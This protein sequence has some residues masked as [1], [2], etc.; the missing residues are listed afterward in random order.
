MTGDAWFTQRGWVPFAFQR[1]VWGAMAA[2]RSGLLHASTGSGKTYAVWFGA[3]ARSAGAILLVAQVHG[4]DND[5]QGPGGVHVTVRD[6]GPGIPPL[7]LEQIFEAFVQSSTTRDGS[8]G[9]GL[10]L[11]ISRKIIAAHGGSIRAEN[12]PDGGSRFHIYL[13]PVRNPN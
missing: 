4:G 7:E 3:L 8:G 1:E 6:H 12:R 13:P 2:G 11:A 10:G 9:T 5:G